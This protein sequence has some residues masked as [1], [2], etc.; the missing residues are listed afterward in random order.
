MG[1][2]TFSKAAT[3]NERLVRVT[4]GDAVKDGGKAER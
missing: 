1:C 3:V 2:Q 4:E